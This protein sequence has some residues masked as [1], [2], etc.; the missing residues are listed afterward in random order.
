MVA[1]GG[2]ENAA[3]GPAALQGVLA[4]AGEHVAQLLPV[5]QITAVPQGHPGEELKGAVHQVVV[6][7]HPADTGVGVKTGE[8]GIFK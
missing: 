8:D 6:L 3:G 4:G 5:E 2:G 1:D 7:A